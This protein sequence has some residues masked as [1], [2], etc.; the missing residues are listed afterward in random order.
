ML[1]LLLGTI[2]GAAENNVYTTIIIAKIQRFYYFS[3]SI[4]ILNFKYWTIMSYSVTADVKVWR[5]RAFGKW[6]CCEGRASR[7]GW[8]PL[9]KRPAGACLPLCLVRTQQEGI[10]FEAESHPLSDTGSLAPW[11]CILTLA[12]PASRIVNNFYCS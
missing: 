10:F 7:V 11:I 4:C 1:L 12:L 6:L 2:L 5:G 8:L 9:Q 3:I